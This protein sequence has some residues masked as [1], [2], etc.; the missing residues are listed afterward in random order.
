MCPSRNVCPRP[1]NVGLTWTSAPA[2]PKAQPIKLTACV[3][4]E[5]KSWITEND[6]FLHT[7][8][9]MSYKMCLGF[10]RSTSAGSCWPFVETRD[11][12]DRSQVHPGPMRLQLQTH[13]MLQ[14]HLSLLLACGQRKRDYM[15]C[16][17]LCITNFGLPTLAILGMAN[18]LQRSF[19]M[20]SALSPHNHMSTCS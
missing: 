4:C 15:T 9:R 5:F 6:D 10:Q 18:T 11:L 12:T 8:S 7:S 20:H 17:R 14:G 16:M 2:R 13:C 19:E 3:G 1:A